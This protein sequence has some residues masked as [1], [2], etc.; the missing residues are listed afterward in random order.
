MHEDEDH[1]GRARYTLTETE[2]GRVWGVC[3]EVEGLFGE[4]RRGTYELFGWVPE[5]AEARGWAGSQVWLVPEDGTLDPWLLEDAESLGRHPGTDGLV[6][7]G[8]DD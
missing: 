1:R 3:P 7:T 6:F 2:H 4:P 5:G 8:M